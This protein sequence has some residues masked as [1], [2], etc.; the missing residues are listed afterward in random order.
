MLIGERIRHLREE[1]GL[2]RAD[3]EQATGLLRSYVCRVELGQSIPSLE[4]LERFAAALEVPLYWL[5]YAE[6]PDDNATGPRFRPDAAQPQPERQLSGGD[7]RFLMKLAE[8]TGRRVE[9]DP[10]FLLDFARQQALGKP[11]N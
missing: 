2:S 9:A 11:E 7:A 5:F 8:L 4:A 1:R 10:A 6:E 3:I